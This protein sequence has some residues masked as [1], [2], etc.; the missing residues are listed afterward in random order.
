MKIFELNLFGFTIAPTYYGLMYILW[1]LYGLWFLKKSWRYTDKQQENLFLYIFTWVL[2]GW[3]I[4]Y[5]LFYN[6][7]SY[8]AHPLNIFKFWEGGMSFHWGFLWVVIALILFTRKYKTPFWKLADDIALIIPVGLFFGRIGNYLNK[9][10]LGFPY[11]WLLA[12]QTNDGSYFPS[13]LIEALLEWLI[14]FVI[15]NIVVRQQ[16][17][18]W[19]IAALFLVLYG[20]FRTFVELFIRLPDPQIWYYFWFFTQ[21]SFLSMPMILVWIIL[22]IYLKNNDTAK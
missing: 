2:I 22:Y 7:S 13:P 8:I 16:K 11:S 4:W 18:S 3:R 1:F 17:F 12:V 19:Q 15:L 14:I 6:L 20:I 5:I 9:E 10:L 21:G